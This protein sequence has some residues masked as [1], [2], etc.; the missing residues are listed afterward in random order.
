MKKR[1]SRSSDELVKQNLQQLPQIC[2]NRTKEE[3]YQNI[4][5][6]TGKYG[7]KRWPTKWVIP[8]LST[9]A[10]LLLLLVLLPNMLSSPKQYTAD[11]DS[12]SIENRQ[13]GENS[14]ENIT[15]QE[16][17]DNSLENPERSK[18]E[19]N[20]IT[21]S[22]QDEESADETADKT[23]EET[24]THEEPAVDA[25][26]EDPI[27][28]N[29]V[30]ALTEDDIEQG[31]KA[32]TIP[33]QDVETSVIVPLTFVISE[34]QEPLEAF[35]ELTE[36]FTGEDVGLD[37]SALQH[38]D[39]TF[40]GEEGSPL[41]AEFEED[42]SE[43]SSNE[44]EMIVRSL[45]ESMRYLGEK[46][47]ILEQ[48]GEEGVELGN[49]GVLNRYRID[50]ENRG[51]YVYT[52]NEN[53]SFLVSGSGA[54]ISST[55]ENGELLTFHETLEHMKSTGEN[56][57][58]NAS[59]PEDMVIKEVQEEQDLARV[60]FSKDSHLSENNN[61][62]LMVEAVLFAAADFGFERVSFEGEN[63]GEAEGYKLHAPI[64]VPVAP[65]QIK[66]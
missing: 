58:V 11:E 46:E 30:T 34:S 14:T 4:V 6:K 16:E 60:V 63:L 38:I 9:A 29:Y 65:N 56:S 19:E 59:I 24:Q 17:T 57:S 47:V 28:D 54:N 51:Y 32:V 36:E 41:E 13:A 22:E 40:A 52:T 61:G 18:Q 49:Y 21:I 35:E 45:E 55:N 53:R 23:A 1:Y 43:A 44:S 37:P 66:K 10:A 31:E 12:A 25:E 48:N 20:D 64:D 39:W 27:Y 7:N 62:R 42:L 50:Q 15:E 26:D 5:K 33:L 2:D 3:V 8:T